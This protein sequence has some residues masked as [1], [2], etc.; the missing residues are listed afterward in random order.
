MSVQS[1]TSSR[2]FA[3]F[4]VVGAGL[5][6]G[7]ATD[8]AMTSLSPAKMAFI[9]GG[10]ALLIPTIV[11]RDPKIY[12][13]F[14]LVLSIP[15]DISKWLSDPGL[16][17]TLV[18]TYGFPGTGTDSLE[19][20]VTDVVLVAMLLPW[21]VRVCLRQEEL[22]FPKVGYIFVF[23]LA[24][25]LLISLINAVAFS[26]TYFE[27][28]RQTLYFLSFVYLINNLTTR[29]QIRSV[30]WAI[31]VG[32]IISAGTVIV[33]FEKGIGTEN[34]AFAGLHDQFEG[35]QQSSTH[36][37]SSHSHGVGHQDLTINGQTG[38]HLGSK[39]EESGTKRSQGMFRHP[40]IP[41]SLAG[42]ILPIILAYFVAA[43]SGR[44]R[45]IFL[46][47]YIWGFVALLLT[48]SRAG[49][50]GLLVGSLVFAVAAGWSG[51]ISRQAAKRTAV[52]FALTV[53]LS[54]PL[55][56]MYMETRPG[57]FF[58]RFTLF[59]TALDGYAQHPILGVGLGN[60]TAAMQPSRRELKEIGLPVTP[61]EAVDSYYLD[62]LTEVGPLGT[63]LL[64]GFYGKI[65][66]TGLD[67]ARRVAVDMKP[68]LVG[69][70][71]GIASLATQSL[72]DEPS[73]GHAVSGMFWLFAALIVAIAR[74]IQP[75]QPAGP[76]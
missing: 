12:W 11:I 55:L 13:L 60:G 62:I 8:L 57:A 59:E 75:S 19:I 61:G 73:Q 10:F 5:F 2:L 41:A 51:L 50:L 28:C 30:V 31:I 20:Y 21:L 44:D 47:V 18:D 70:V 25:A 67:A 26:F 29:S 1:A 76:S 64:F 4:G 6:V 45:I 15:F 14:L 24:W 27:L 48:F 33:F 9:L 38:S 71:A 52:A 35:G 58:M 3:T 40:A 43:K 23:Y 72:V 74:Q 49:L 54:M 17:Q 22:Y 42:L 36:K 16:T 68:L 56:L 66:M 7:L 63:L 46:M 34:S 39:D 65:V 37:S 32:F 69:M 53:A